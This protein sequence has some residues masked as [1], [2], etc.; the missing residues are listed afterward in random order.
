MFS[1][2]GEY[3][4]GRDEGAQADHRPVAPCFGSSL[5]RNAAMPHGAFIAQ[6]HYII[7]SSH[8]IQVT[9]IDDGG[10]PWVGVS[11]SLSKMRPTQHP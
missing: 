9:I 7:K 1:F 11:P 3:C 5:F 4:A 8:E 6:D 2:L 10:R